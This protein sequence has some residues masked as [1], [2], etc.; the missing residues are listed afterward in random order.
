MDKFRLESVLEGHRKGLN[1]V[2][3]ARLGG[4]EVAVSSSDDLRSA[5]LLLQEG[6]VVHL[7]KKNAKIKERTRK[8][9]TQCRDWT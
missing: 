9:K 4:R 8:A 3:L 1:S 5:G 7:S 6:Q 2:Q